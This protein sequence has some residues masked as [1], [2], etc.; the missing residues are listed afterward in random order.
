M[1][2]PAVIG[3]AGAGTMGAGIAELACLSGA[4][5]LLHDPQPEALASGVDRIRRDLRRSVERGRLRESDAAAAGGRLDTVVELDGFGPC[6]LVIEAAPESL[7]LKRELFKRL[8]EVVS[9]DCVLATNTSSLPVTAIA[10]GL[11]APQRVVGMHFFNPAPV[12]RLL[13]VVAGEESSAEALARASAAGEA[14]G[15]RVI[16][17]ADGPGFLVNRCA[18]PYGLEATRLLVEGVASVQEIDRICRLGGGFRLG[19]FELADLVGLDTRLFVERSFYEQSYGEPR[20]RPSP[21]TSR[22]VAAGRLGR[23]SGRGFY[24]YSGGDYREPDAEAP[25]PGRGDGVVVIA[26]DSSLAME[27]A[28]SA[29]SAGFAVVSPHEAAQSGTVPE[30][31][32]D[33]T[34]GEEAA[35]PLQGG[36]QALCCAAGSLAALD[37]GGNAVGFHALPPF[38]DSGLVELTRGPDSA[39]TAAT[40]AERFFTTLGKRVSWVGD[41]PGLVLGRIVAQ[42]VNEAAFAL[43]ERV[44]TA[45]DIDAGLVHGMNYPRGALAWGDMIGLNHVLAVLDG[46]FEERHEERYRAAPMLRS[47]VWNGR[48][49]RLTGEGFFRY[50]D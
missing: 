22:L 37:P 34:G 43:T 31:I 25:P 17:A 21:I 8:A 42:L 3:I 33:L 49:G 45:E 19:P 6:E 36:S 10:G 35:A 30:L 23:K 39:L 29:S 44:G 28:E 5:T 32:L 18:R 26:G 24:D 12:M 4:R 14:M 46:L 16:Q 41:C 47:M 2:A 50:E 1:T 40:R 9:D 15:K 20:W 48:L 7:E 27:L 13:E 11:R 38:A